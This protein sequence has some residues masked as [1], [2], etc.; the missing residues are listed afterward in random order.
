M[1][2]RLKTDIVYPQDIISNIRKETP[3]TTGVKA[4]VLGVPSIADEV[5]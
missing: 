5:S 1:R 3:I 2:S 4:K